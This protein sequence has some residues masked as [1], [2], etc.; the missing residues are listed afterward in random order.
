MPTT[1][2][3]AAK[4]PTTGKTTPVKSGDT[5][6]AP[7]D[8]FPFAQYVSVLGVHLILVGFTALYLPQTT[9]LFAPLAARKTDKPQSEFMEAL[10]A[11]PSL[12]LSWIF[13]GLTLLEVWWASWMRKWSF[14]QTA[15]GTEVEI[16]FARVRFNSLHF[17]VRRYIEAMGSTTFTHLTVVFRD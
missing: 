7:V 2:A 13:V 12:T 6:P 4:P 10:T 8:P 16:K 11:E 9:R 1:R 5:V 17:T 3:R 15:K 14:E